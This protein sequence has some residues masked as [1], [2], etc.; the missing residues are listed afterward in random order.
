MIAFDIASLAKDCSH[1]AASSSLRYKHYAKD[2]L[3]LNT[4]YFRLWLMKY[5]LTN[6]EFQNWVTYYRWIYEFRHD[7]YLQAY[8]HHRHR[9]WRF[10]AKISRERAEQ[11]AVNM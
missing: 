11:C 8:R 1:K 2:Y 3:I 7:Y 10:K 9:K 4:H 5:G 6:G